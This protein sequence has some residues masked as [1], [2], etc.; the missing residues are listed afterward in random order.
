MID[1]NKFIKLLV[2]GSILVF[3]SAFS[4]FYASIDEMKDFYK[5]FGHKTQYLKLLFMFGYYFLMGFVQ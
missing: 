5:S 4:K 1:I 3:G 2:A